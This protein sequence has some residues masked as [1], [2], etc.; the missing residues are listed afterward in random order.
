MGISTRNY[1]GYSDPTAY[2]AVRNMESDQKKLRIEYPN[3]YMELHLDHF[4]PANVQR[5]KKIFILISRY[6]SDAEKRRLLD[7]LQQRIKKAEQQERTFQAK[8][9]AAAEEYAKLQELPESQ[10]RIVKIE[11]REHQAKLKAARN[12]KKLLIRN[13]ELFREKWRDA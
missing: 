5:A 2:A 4:F 11:Y 9:D 6:C 3:G 12:I 13:M 7:Y 1:E 8:V 10:V